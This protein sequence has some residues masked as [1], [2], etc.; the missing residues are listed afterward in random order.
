[1]TSPP[2]SCSAREP[3]EENLNAPINAPAF[4]AGLIRRA[5]ER[6]WQQFIVRFP[7][8]AAMRVLDLGGT[9]ASWLEGRVRPAHVTLVNLPGEASRAT[10]EA[11]G[12]PW[13]DVVAGDAC[14][15]RASWGRFDLVYSNSVIEHVGGH[16][17]RRR[18]ADTVRRHADAHW[19]QTPYRYFPIEPHYRLPFIQ[20]LPV[21]VGAKLMRAWPYA[22]VGDAQRQD[23]VADLLTIE[24]LSFA[25]MRHYFPGSA[26]IPE[27][28]LGLPKGLIAVAPA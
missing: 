7:D 28:F 15:V 9:A 10:R 3:S 4:L 21:S 18:F 23:P 20:H 19:V 8:I 12:V 22:A 17:Q 2:A 13:I 6:R 14:D 26:V 24:L 27:S 1:M 16:E 5:H 11:A 25:E